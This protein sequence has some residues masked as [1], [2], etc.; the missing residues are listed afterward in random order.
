MVQNLEV[1]NEI[2]EYE[3]VHGHEISSVSVMV[4]AGKKGN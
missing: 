1:K 3:A 4:V 2:Y